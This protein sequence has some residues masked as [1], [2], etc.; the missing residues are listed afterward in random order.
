MK[1][2]RTSKFLFFNAILLS[3]H[4]FACIC[5]SQDDETDSTLSSGVRKFGSVFE[6]DTARTLIEHTTFAE[7]PSQDHRGGIFFC[8]KD[9]QTIRQ[10]TQNGDIVASINTPGGCNGLAIDR[11]GNFLICANVS[12]QIVKRSPG[13]IVTVLADSFEGKPFVFPNDIW[14]DPH[15]GFYFTD[16]N[17]SGEGGEGDAVYYMRPDLKTLLRVNHDMPNPN[18]VTG[19]PDGTTLYV[20]NFYMGAK[21]ETYAFDIEPG[22]TLAN[23]RMFAPAGEDGAAVDSAGNVYVTGKTLTV[24]SPG[25]IK[26]D[27]IE[28]P[29]RELL[30]NCAFVG[31]GK[32]ILLVTG[33]NGVYSVRS[34]TPGH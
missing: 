31:P 9:V 13:G 28:F 1:S 11:D 14:L 24:W 3:L 6:H 34:T 4:F 5:Y 12:K 22:G 15:G 21:G 25:G 8:E 10:I 23:K 26:L 29:E 27:E 7:G 19:S 18:G 33:W 17:F 16:T 32:Q 20:T 30:T 2:P